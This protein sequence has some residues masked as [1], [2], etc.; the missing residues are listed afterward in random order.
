MAREQAQAQVS[1]ASA[2]DRANAARS[3]ELTRRRWKE[4]AL[5]AVTSLACYAMLAAIACTVAWWAAIRV[6]LIPVLGCSLLLL[7]AFLIADVA[8]WVAGLVFIVLAVT[9]LIRER[10]GET[11]RA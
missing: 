5:R 2:N 9:L 1:L 6:T 10:G 4:T 3:R 8:T 7:I 11:G